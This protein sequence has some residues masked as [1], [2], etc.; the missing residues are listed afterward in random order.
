MV[1]YIL[2]CNACA[3]VGS[4]E[5]LNLINNNLKSFP[6]SFYSNGRF[7]TALLDAFVKCDDLASAQLLFDSIKEKTTEIYTVIMN[8]LNKDDQ[9]EKTIELFKQME[10]NNIERDLVLYLCLIK[11]LAKVG[12]QSLSQ[13]MIEHI[14]GNF[15]STNEI[16]TALVDMWV[17]LTKYLL[18]VI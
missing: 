2:F 14:P 18:Y 12:V 9:P 4:N 13:S 5:A 3:Q 15:L 6:K 10:K 8:G 1:I 7:V 11:A 16:Q 17:C